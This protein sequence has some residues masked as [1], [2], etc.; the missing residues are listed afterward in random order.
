MRILVT[1]GSGFIGTRLVGELLSKGHVVR[2]LD[3]VLSSTYLDLCLVGDVRDAQAV[4]AATKDIDI[5]YHLAAE[6]KDDVRPVS[7]YY[8]VNVD[9]ARNLAE[10]CSANGVSRLIFT[11][12]VAVYGLNAGEPSEEKP[13]NPFNDYSRS[14]LEAE[15]VFQ[16]WAGEKQ[17]RNLSIVRPTVIFG[18]GNRGNV[19]NLVHQIA[20]GHFIM[21]GDGKNKKSM[22]YIGNIVSFLVS[23]ID[24]P[25][26]GTTV[27]NYSDKP[28]LSMNELVGLVRR[29]IGKSGDP[30][31][32]IPY[33]IGIFG[34]VCFDMLSTLTGKRFPISSVRIKKFCANTTIA[35]G[36]LRE[37]G[38]SPPYTLSRGMEM[39]LDHEITTRI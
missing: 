39:F 29:Y 36:K 11:S 37:T 25:S 14:K 28:D 6:H 31:V 33:W 20:A 30:A 3:K 27:F 19:Y 35:V 17:G 21:V 13:T 24:F 16:Q 4:N 22:A 38:F 5:V 2:I 12:S 23:M 34:G 26:S 7:L 8:E 1:G 15:G 18:E 32:R 9:G 10:A